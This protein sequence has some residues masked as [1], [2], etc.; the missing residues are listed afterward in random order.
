LRLCS[1]KEM[2]VEGHLRFFLR[3]FWLSLLLE[4]MTRGKKWGKTLKIYENS[5]NYIPIYSLM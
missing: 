1:Q 5:N 3:P 4:T 2:N